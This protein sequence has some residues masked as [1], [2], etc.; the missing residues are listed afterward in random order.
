MNKLL[1]GMISGFAATAPMSAVM[2]V[3][4]RMLPWM[5][6]YPLPPRKVTMNVARALGIKQGMSEPQREAATVAA[7]FGYGA[8]MGGIYATFADRLPASPISSGVVWGLIVWAGSYLGLLP[9]L[10]LHESATDHPQQ[11]NWLMIIAHVVWGASLGAIL[12]WALQSDASPRRSASPHGQAARPSRSSRPASA[13]RN[14]RT[15]RRAAAT[16][17]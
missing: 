12:K 11:R 15:P 2:I 13:R 1:V 5:Q 14:T 3:M 8:G 4:H 6:R 10:G 9:S 17:S 7:H 16:R